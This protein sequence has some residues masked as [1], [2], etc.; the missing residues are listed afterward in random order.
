MTCTKNNFANNLLKTLIVPVIVFNFLYFHS[1]I[2]SAQTATEN[3]APPA[4]ADSQ[5]RGEVVAPDIQKLKQQLL[6][7][8]VK[9]SDIVWLGPTQQVLALWRPETSGNPFGAVLIL[10]DD[11]HHPDWPATIN[12]VRN[13]LP[14]FGWATLSVS[15]PDTENK[16]IPP[17]PAPTPLTGTS[18]SNPTDAEDEHAKETAKLM[19]QDS[20]VDEQAQQLAQAASAE[21]PQQNMPNTSD[22]P[23]PELLAH[24]QI[25]AAMD[26]LN[27]KGQF[28][29]IVVAYGTSAYRAAKYIDDLMA[30]NTSNKRSL[31]VQGKMQRPVRAVV[32]VS[33]RNHIVTQK[34][35]LTDYLNDRNV[36]MLDVYFGDH[37][38]DA[39]ESKERKLFTQQNNFTQYFQVKI[40]PPSTEVFDG[41]TPLTRRIRG[42]INKHARGVKVGG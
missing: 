17:R 1:A 27:E 41:E 20:E 4:A 38:L 14:Q 9:E 12:P 25:Q 36:P 8:E 29:I 13:N 6:K 30:G 16:Q 11:G 18:D 23:D 34:E 33:A 3:S 22:K 40:E 32:F 35:N 19:A 39:T 7:G 5:T 2:S 24:Q 42:F 21:N 26:F 15:M 31:K 28:N 37:H 10:H